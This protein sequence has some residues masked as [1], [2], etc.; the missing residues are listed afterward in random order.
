MRDLKPILND[1]VSQGKGFMFISLH[2]LNMQM[3]SAFVIL[4]LP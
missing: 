1:N 3:F 2:V 4:T